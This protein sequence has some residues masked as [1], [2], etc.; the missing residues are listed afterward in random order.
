MTTEDIDALVK[1]MRLL[2]IDHE[3]EGWPAV[4]MRDISALC[5]ALDG[6]C[7]LQKI[8]EKRSGSIQRNN[9]GDWR[10]CDK[11][12]APL[13]EGKSLLAALDNLTKFCFAWINT[14]D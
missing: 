5:D 13:A 6:V 2:Q 14:H 11:N 8:F 9:C 3:P 10:I 12:D 1:R 4:K 7:L